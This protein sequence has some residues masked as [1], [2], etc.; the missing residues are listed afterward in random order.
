MTRVI[1]RSD[2]GRSGSRKPCFCRGRWRW[3]LLRRARSFC[4]LL[5]RLLESCFVCDANE[6]IAFG[7]ALLLPSGK[8]TI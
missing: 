3:L 1:A 5:L 2:I 7:N 6:N 8:Q 4:C